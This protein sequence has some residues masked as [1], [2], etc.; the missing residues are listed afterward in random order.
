MIDTLTW[1]TKELIIMESDPGMMSWLQE[2]KRQI[3]NMVAENRFELWEDENETTVRNGECTATCS[4]STTSTCIGNN[5]S[6]TPVVFNL[7]QSI[8]RTS[9]D[10]FHMS[11]FI[12]TEA[13]KLHFRIL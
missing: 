5:E 8:P 4:E 1:K 10:P 7:P 13:Q 12:E 6:R 2:W 9:N 3:L 11:G